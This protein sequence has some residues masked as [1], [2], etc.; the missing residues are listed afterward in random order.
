LSCPA[1]SLLG[2]DLIPGATDELKPQL[3]QLD[4]G[5]SI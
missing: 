4:N 3:M 1:K 2:S 5:T